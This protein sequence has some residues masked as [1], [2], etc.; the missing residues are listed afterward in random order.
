M[1]LNGTYM[2]YFI[3]EVDYIIPLHFDIL[4]KAVFDV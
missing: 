3:V 1:L 4:N 2:Y